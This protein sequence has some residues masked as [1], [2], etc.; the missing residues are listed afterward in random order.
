MPILLPCVNSVELL[1]INIFWRTFLGP[2]D[3]NYN[4]KSF[5]RLYFLIVDQRVRGDVEEDGVDPLEAER[6][7]RQP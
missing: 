3:R 7:L 1:L 2:I 5:L 6:S 4:I